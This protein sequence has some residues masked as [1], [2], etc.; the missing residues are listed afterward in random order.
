MRHGDSSVIVPA[1]LLLLSLASQLAAQR[2]QAERL[3]P[4]VPSPQPVVE[5]ML[6]AAELKPGETVFD[7]GCGDGRILITAAREFKAK[8]VGVELSRDLV[9]RAQD[10]VSRFGLQNRVTIIQ[11]DLLDVDLKPADVVTLYLLTDSNEKLKPLFE[12]DLR[13]GARVVSHDFMIRGWEPERIETVFA[14]HRMHSIYV[15]LMP[16]QRPQKK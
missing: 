2:P 12:R 10:E 15:Y 6:S 13:R 8:G 3:A 16:P 5:R 4:F 14:T 11:G 1:L 9:R 7:L